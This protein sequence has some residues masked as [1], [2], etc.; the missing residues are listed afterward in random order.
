MAHPLVNAINKMNHGNAQRNL[1]DTIAAFYAFS[2]PLTLTE[3]R[4]A[5]GILNGNVT[6]IGGHVLIIAIK[7]KVC[8]QCVAYP[9]RMCNKLIQ[10]AS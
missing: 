3:K 5:I 2:D 9:A 8:Y 7:S 10:R 6:R 1:I 4:A